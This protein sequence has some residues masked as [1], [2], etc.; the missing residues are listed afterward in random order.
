M[1][2]GSRW[3]IWKSRSLQR[4]SMDL[5]F[6]FS[7][8][9]SNGNSQGLMH[10]SNNLCYRWC[11][12][13][14]QIMR[15]YYVALI[16]PF[17]LYFSYKF[18]HSSLEIHL[19]LVTGT[20]ATCCVYLKTIADTTYADEYYLKCWF[21]RTLGKSFAMNRL[22][23]LLLCSRVGFARPIFKWFQCLHICDHV[24]DLLL[25]STDQNT[26]TPCPT[27]YE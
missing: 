12:K 25:S 27:L 8:K 16:I 6:I 3:S 23:R 17:F 15:P 11:T 26:G 22:F 5:F 4:S 13:T 1:E 18:V 21:F 10:L 9:K 24:G 2:S 20:V 7:F 19:V 14:K